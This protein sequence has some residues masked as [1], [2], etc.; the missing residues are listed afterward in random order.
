[1]AR[2]WPEKETGPQFTEI[3]DTVYGNLLVLSYDSIQTLH[4]KRGKAAPTHDLIEAIAREAA[5]WPGSKIL[6]DIGA[7]IGVYTVALAPLFDCVI[8][9]EPEPMLF[10]ILCGNIA[11]NNLRNVL[12]YRMVLS[13]TEEDYY[14][15]IVD[16]SAENNFGNITWTKTSEEAAQ[17]KSVDSLWL[18]KLDRLYGA[19]FMKIDVEGMEIEVLRGATKF[20]EKHRP[21]MFI[22]H[23][24]T[25]VRPITE[26]LAP[27]DYDFETLRLDVVARPKVR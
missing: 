3:V 23:T 6:F 11:L 16:Y 5:K 27:F 8:A 13:D 7:N 20:I 22:E 10:N 14:Y 1:M 24:T 26:F 15:N 12:P 17:S 25:G 4:L 9:V 21:T 2:T 19:A 18:N